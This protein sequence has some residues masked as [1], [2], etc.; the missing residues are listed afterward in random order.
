MLSSVCICKQKQRFGLVNKDRWTLNFNRV[1]LWNGEIRTGDI[2]FNQSAG[3]N[4]R[5]STNDEF[6]QDGFIADATERISRSLIALYR[7]KLL[8]SDLA[9][10]ILRILSQTR[11]DR[12]AFTTDK[13]R[14]W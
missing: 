2:F 7:D 14:D 12:I 10:S 5:R 13:L 11:L 8:E 6:E 9:N 3:D 1:N 4:P